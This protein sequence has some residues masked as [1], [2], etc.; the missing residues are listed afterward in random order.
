MKFFEIDI[1]T[2]KYHIPSFLFVVKI[3]LSL[4]ERKKTNSVF[5]ENHDKIEQNILELGLWNVLTNSH[6]GFIFMVSSKLSSIHFFYFVFIYDTCC[7]LLV[8]ILNMKKNIKLDSLKLKSILTDSSYVIN[9][10]TVIKSL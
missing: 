6:L 9:D 7:S 2:N 4:N 1:I 3:T 10:K 5:Q 8:E